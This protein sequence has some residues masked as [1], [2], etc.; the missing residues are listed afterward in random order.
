MIH[1][2]KHANCL[3]NVGQMRTWLPFSSSAGAPPGAPPGAEEADLPPDPRIKI[4]HE[5]Q[6]NATPL[7]DDTHFLKRR[8][9]FI[10]SIDMP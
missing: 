7:L 8:S 6:N 1:I 5:F 4:L 2:I 3:S 9:E 10:Y